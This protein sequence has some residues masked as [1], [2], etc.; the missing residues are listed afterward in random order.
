[1]DLGAD[2]NSADSAGDTPLHLAAKCGFAGLVGVLRRGGASEVSN[3]EGKTPK[4][5][6]DSAIVKA[7]AEEVSQ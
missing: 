6:G 5:L 1:M 2:P 7:L 4:D 3:N